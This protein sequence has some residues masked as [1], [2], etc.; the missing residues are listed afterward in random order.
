[1]LRFIF[2][3]TLTAFI[4]TAPVFAHQGEDAPAT[5]VEIGTLFGLS[6]FEVSSETSNSVAREKITGKVT[7]IGVPGGFP[8]LY[9]SWFPS[10]QL[11]IGPEFSFWRTSFDFEYEYDEKDYDWD[12][13]YG[14]AEFHLST[15]Y[16]GVRGAL[17]PQSNAVSGLYLLG[18]G[19]LMRISGGLRAE[20]GKADISMHNFVAETGLGYQLRVGP[21]F[22][23]KMEGKYRR[24]FAYSGNVDGSGDFDVDGSGDFDIDGG[25]NE[26]FLTLSLGTRLPQ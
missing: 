19:A 6:R 14:R 20:D 9:V 13:E 12:D 16:L 7:S 21:A 25:L 11:A 17:F 15:F 24:R 23:V 5:G 8:L 26:F 2:F 3:S 1:M 18:S 4:A 10:E 22:V